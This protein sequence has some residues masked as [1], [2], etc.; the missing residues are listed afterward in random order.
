MNFFGGDNLLIIRV[1]ATFCYQ[2]FRVPRAG[3]VYARS[4]LTGLVNKNLW[5]ACNFLI[6]FSSISQLSKRQ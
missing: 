2:Q 5:P 4:V 6:L 3:S 1:K